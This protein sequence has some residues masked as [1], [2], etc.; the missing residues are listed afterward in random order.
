MGVPSKLALHIL[1]E[2]LRISEVFLEKSL[3]FGLRNL[4]STFV[5]ALVLGTSIANDAIEEFGG[6]QGMIHSY[7]T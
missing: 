3:E 6:K 1:N 7:N 2:S 5:A 4:N